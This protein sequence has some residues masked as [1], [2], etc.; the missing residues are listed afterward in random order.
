MSTVRWQR[1]VPESLRALDTLERPDYVDL[2]TGMVSEAVV[3]TPEQWIRAT[4]NG[5]PRSLLLLVPFIQR[6]ILGLRLQLRPS[7]DHVLGWKIAERGGNWIR[8]EAASWF[9]T[10]HVIM[11]IADGQMSF[12]TFVRYERFP[13]ALVWPPISLIH[14]RV[15][16]E[17]VRSATRAG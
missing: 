16:L 11:R 12:A 3:M 13:A 14:R 15:A 8:I 6:T 10:G 2:V 1:D 4:L 9:L 7:P 5:L 17:L